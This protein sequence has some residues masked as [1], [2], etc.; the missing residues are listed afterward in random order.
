MES[1]SLTL[2]DRLRVAAAARGEE[3]LAEAPTAIKRLGM[4]FMALAISVPLFLAGC[5]AVL[6]WFLL[7]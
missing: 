3:F 1:V 7:T 2:G 6:A 4:L 5:L